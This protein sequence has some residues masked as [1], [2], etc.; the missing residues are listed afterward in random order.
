LEKIKQIR[1]MANQYRQY[2]AECLSEMVKIPSLS[3]GEEKVEK[4]KSNLKQRV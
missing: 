2:S 1:D 3:A 4:L